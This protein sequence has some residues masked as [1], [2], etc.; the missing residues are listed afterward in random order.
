MTKQI[1]N[2]ANTVG[3]GQLRRAFP[4]ARVIEGIQSFVLRTDG[5]WHAEVATVN[6]P[7]AVNLAWDADRLHSHLTTGS[8]RETVF[9][10]KT[11]A[12]EALAAGACPRCAGTGRVPQ[13]QHVDGGRCFD[14]GGSGKRAR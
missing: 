12:A 8:T 1:H 7:I 2:P 5:L 10:G 6:G 3:L 9:D 13:F 14:C 11:A 4:G